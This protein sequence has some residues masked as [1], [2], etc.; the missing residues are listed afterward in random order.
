[1]METLLLMMVAHLFVR[2]NHA[3][4]IVHVKAGFS[5]LLMDYAQLPVGIK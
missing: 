4:K 1:M 5:L 3:V 2:F